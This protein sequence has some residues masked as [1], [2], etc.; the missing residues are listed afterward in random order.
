MTYYSLDVQNLSASFS[1]WPLFSNL[2]FT[3]KSTEC[4][5]IIGANGS[6]KTTLLRIIAGLSFASAGKLLWKSQTQTLLTPLEVTFISV[7][8][9]LKNNLRVFEQL[10]LWQ[11]LKGDISTLSLSKLTQASEKILSHFDLQE[12]WDTP[13]RYLSAGQRQSLNLCQLFLRPTPL[14]ILDE[15]FAHLD[16]KQVNRLSEIMAL[17]LS[18]KGLIITASPYD[19]HHIEGQL[20]RLEHFKP[21]QSIRENDRW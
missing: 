1:K 10:N 12:L 15:P 21:T 6:G 3:I 4:L 16:L 2:S 9:P 20:L 8:P 5:K 11:L 13:I 7:T 18:Q 19:V 17:H 14:W